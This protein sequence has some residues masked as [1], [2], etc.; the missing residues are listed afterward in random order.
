MAGG[1][2]RINIV[3]V[4]VLS[5]P[6]AFRQFS[7]PHL[8]V[9]EEHLFWLPTFLVTSALLGHLFVIRRL[10]KPGTK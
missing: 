4:A 6:R 1:N 8:F 3:T 10:S 5:M 9:A 2:G 7:P